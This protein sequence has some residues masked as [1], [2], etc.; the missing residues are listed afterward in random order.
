[1]SEIKLSD[2][3]E[4]R[5]HE[6]GS[7]VLDPDEAR[8]VARVLEL[9]R[10]LCE[11]LGANRPHAGEGK[12]EVDLL[13]TIDLLEDLGVSSEELTEKLETRRSTG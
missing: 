1:M 8:A 9:G 12:V 4:M 2:E 7:A 10:R 5:V 3:V 6:D 13:G 11:D